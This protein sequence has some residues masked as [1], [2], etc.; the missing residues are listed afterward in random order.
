MSPDDLTDLE[1]LSGWR[2]GDRRMGSALYR[3]HAGPI[4]NFFRRNARSRADV[5]DL[6]QETFVALRESDSEIANVSGY[7]YRIA[8]F[9]LIRY[10]DRVSGRPEQEDDAAALERVAG[11]LVPEPEYV[12]A[13]REDMRLLL[14]AIRRLPLKH[15]LV[16]ELSFWG[17]KSGPEIAEILDVPL[18]TVASRLR[19]AKANLEAMLGQLADSQE[20]LRATTT[21]LGQW[22]TRIHELLAGSPPEAP[23]SCAPGRDT[24]PGD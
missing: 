14:R 4:T 18:G 19:H 5:E 15:Q 20:A 3:R 17:E 10:I 11:E 21:T 6:T 7:L 9:K 2:R 16:I 24:E 22:R 13:Q 8:R 12:R 1:L 23:A